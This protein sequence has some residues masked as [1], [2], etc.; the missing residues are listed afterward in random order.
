MMLNNGFPAF[1]SDFDT[2]LNYYIA[3][4]EENLKKYL[5][6]FS[7][8]DADYQELTNAFRYSLS[9]VG[10]R[11]RP[12]L[13]FEF[14]RICGGKIENALPAA[15][16]IEMIHT[17]SLIHDDLPC[18][19]NDDMRRGKPSCHKAFG[20]ANALLAGDALTVKAFQVISDSGIDSN[21]I[22]NMISVLC[23]CSYN[24]IGGQVIDIKGDISDYSTL[25]KMYSFKTSQLI[26]ASCLMG[27]HAAMAD[28]SK[29]KFAEDFAYNLGIAFQ[30]IDDIL[31]VTADEKILGKPVGSDEDQNKNTS[32]TLLG[33]ERANLEA[34][35]YTKKAV[36][37]LNEFD[38]HQFLLQL[39]NQL[40]GRKK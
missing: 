27:C 40:L 1:D 14:C 23:R 33:L 5:E 24:M 38:N 39:T 17:F 21:I 35:E 32:I 6:R 2:T 22:R 26:I 7:D 15:I 30:I 10:K 3:Y 28:N 20:E 12:V 25:L 34:A 31:D 8:E 13:V 9:A 4:F 16:A 18:M 11:V 36:D 19:D 29:L 37:S